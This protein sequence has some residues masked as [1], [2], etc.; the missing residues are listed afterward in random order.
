MV[1]TTSQREITSLEGEWSTLTPS[2][3]QIS[4][5]S[6]RTM[7]PGAERSNRVAYRWHIPFSGAFLFIFT[8]PRGGSCN[9]PSRFRKNIL[10]SL[11]LGVFPPERVNNIYCLSFPQLGYSSRNLSPARAN[12]SLPACLRIHDGLLLLCSNPLGPFSANHFL[13]RLRVARGTLNSSQLS[14]SV[15][16]ACLNTP[17][18]QLL[19]P[20]I[21]FC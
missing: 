9:Q 1:S 6:T 16:G 5:V 8:K 13:Q 4:K 18:L 20:L 17:I 15:I 7:S 12:T 19:Q 14:L 10:P 3:G 11:E 2:I 21:C